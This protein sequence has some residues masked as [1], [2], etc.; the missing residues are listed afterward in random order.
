MKTTTQSTKQPGGFYV[1]FLTEVWERFGFYLMNS[2]LILYLTKAMGYSDKTAY[3]AFAAFS[4]LLYITPAIGGYLADHFMGY[5]RALSFGAG[6]MAAGYTTL[7]MPF[8]HAMFPALALIVMGNGFFKAM[9]YAL[10]NQLYRSKAQRSKMDGAFTL[11]YLSIQM[12]G[13]APLFLGG[14]AVHYFGWHIT[15]G[16]AAVGMVV[17]CFTFAAGRRCFAKA[18]IEVSSQQLPRWFM[19]AL[20]TGCV[21]VAVIVTALLMYATA[22]SV[23]VWSMAGALVVYVMF[24][25]KN[26]TGRERTRLI[27]ATALCA[28][29]MMFF[30]FYYQQPM[31][32]TLFI[33]R[34]VNRHILGITLP[35]SS[36]WVFNPM[37]ILII[38]PCLNAVY[39]KL[40]KHNR[41][42]S[43][44]MKFSIGMLFMGMGYLTIVV[45]TH[46]A[47][48]SQH[49]SSWWIVG[50]Y[51]FQSTAEL[52]VNALGTAMIAKLVP[53]SM[54]SL[55]MGMW[56]IS[57]SVGGILAG[58][59]A[60]MT[61]VPKAH[62]NA[63]HTMHVYV[64]AFSL[65]AWT[66]FAIGAI[67][68]ICAP[69]VVRMITQANE[70]K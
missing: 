26:L 12:G 43:L 14:F 9:P 3:T 69:M 48:G 47:N 55:M 10:L 1:L 50:S 63:M 56:F 7:A 33:D 44:P 8:H 46:Y 20:T 24:K 5:R 16:A 36:F 62:A 64:H 59:M 40:G 28:F 31:S 45:G 38:G 17:G 52:L 6:M 35:S 67:G 39:N 57:T 15:F 58:T 41:D 51:A 27:V 23:V 29:G 19:P 30:A 2:L 65:F 37:W 34:N 49:I 32:L 70:N 42:L 4:A 25:A 18:D 13:L 21:A 60:N 11:Y 22:A 66:S 68:C 53:K 61:A 54:V